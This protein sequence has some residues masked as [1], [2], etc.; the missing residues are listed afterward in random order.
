MMNHGMKGRE[1]ILDNPKIP[2]QFRVSFRNQPDVP[3]QAQSHRVAV[4][5]SDLYFRTFGHFMCKLF[6]VNEL[7]IK[8]QSGPAYSLEGG[9]TDGISRFKVASQARN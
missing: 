2:G 9:Q 1:G 8:Q 4:S 7:Q 5:R 3:C 6:K